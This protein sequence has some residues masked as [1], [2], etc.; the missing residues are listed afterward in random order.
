MSSILGIAGSVRRGSFNAAL[1]RAA[2]A[3]AP[4]VDIASIAD[5]PLYNG[6]VELEGIPAPVVDLRE[7]IASAGGLLIVTPEYNHSI[8][9]VL[10]NAID[11][12]TRPAADIPRVFGGKPVALMGATPGRGGTRFAQAAWLPV[13]ATLG[14][15]PWFDDELHVAGAAK[16]FDAEG[17]LVDE[18]VRELLA[19]FMRG[20]GAFVE[21]QGRQATGASEQPRV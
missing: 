9:G 20:F 16:V 11:W 10:K 5:I 2:A 12:C 17:T 21:R 15:L 3:L 1:L 19:R 14:T 8:P 13:L 6:D 7:R 4:A 18:K